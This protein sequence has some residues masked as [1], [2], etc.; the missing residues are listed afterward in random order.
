MRIERYFLMTDYSLW[1]VIINGDSPTPIV[2]IEGA[3]Q[4]T[5]ILSADQKLARR[6]ELKARGTLL[7][8]LPDK[9]Q[10]KFN[11][12]K[13]AK[14]LM[15][16]IE[17]R[18]QKLISQLE[19]HGR[20]KTNLEEHSLDDLFNSL[21]IFETEVRH[22]SSL[23]NSTQNLAFMSSSNIDSTTDSVSAATSVSAVCAQLH[24]SSHPNINSLSN[25][26]IFS[27]FASQST[28]P[29]LDNEDLKQIDVDDLKE[30]DL[31]WQMAMLTMRARRFLQKTRR[32]LGDNRVTTIGFDM[33]KVECY[34]CHR[35]GHF[36]Q[37]CKSPK[38]T[39]RTEEEPANFALMAISSSSSASD[40]EVKSCSKAY[41]ELHSQ[42][43]K[44]TVEYRK[45]QI[46]ILLYQAESDSKSLSPSSHSGRIQPSGRYNAVPPP[47]TW[48]FMPPKPDLVFHTA[49]ITVETTHSAFTIQLSPAKPAQDVSHTTRPMAPIIEDWVSDTEDEFEPNDPQNVP[50][51][52]QS[53]EHVKP[54]GHSAQPVEAS[55]LAAT[56]ILTSPKT[57]CSGK[58]KNRK[59]CFVCRSVDHLIKDLL[60]KSKPVF[61]TDV[62]Q[63]SDVVPR[64]MMSRPRHAHPLNT[65]SN[66]SIRRYKTRNQFSKTSNSSLKVTVAKVSMV[67]AVKGKKRKWGNPQYALKDKG[68][69]DSGCSQHMTGNMSYLS[70][71]LELNGGYVAFGGNPK[72][73]KILGKG[74]IK[75]G[76]STKDANQK[77]HRSLPS[78]WS[79]V[80]LIT[81]TKQGVDTLNFDDL[82]NNLRVFESD[83]EESA[84]QKGIK[85]V[86]G[87]M[88]NTGY[89]ARDNRKRSTK[90][91]EHKAMVTIDGEGVH[92]I[93]HA[94]DDTE[95]YA[96]MA[97]NSS[98]SGSDTK[99]TSC[100]KVCEESYAKLKKL[101][102]EQREQL[103]VA[104]IEIKAYTLALKK[105]EAQFVCHQK[106][107]LAYEEKIWFMKI[108]LDDKTNV[109]IYHKKLL[110]EAEKEKKELKTKLENFQSSSKGHSKLLNSQMSP[111]DNLG[112]GYGSQIHD[113]FLSYENEVFASVFDSRSSDVENSPMNDKFAKVEGMHAVPPPMIGNY[114]PPKFDF[115]IDESKFTYSPK[116]STTSKS[117]VKTSY[118][119]SYDFSSSEETL[120]T[121]PKPVANEPKAVSEPKVWPDAPIIE[122]YESD[123]DGEHIELN[124]QKGKHTDP[125]ENKPV[126]NN[127][128]IINHQNKFVPV[129]L[130]KTGRFPVNAARQNFTSQASS[131][132]TARKV[133]TA[134]PKMNEIRP[135]HNVYTS[136]SPIR[137][138]F[139]RTTAPKANFAQ[140]KFNTARDKSDFQIRIQVYSIGKKLR[141]STPGLVLMIKDTWDQEEDIKKEL[142]V[143]K[144]VVH[145]FGRRGRGRRSRGR[146]RRRRKGGAKGIG[147]IPAVVILVIVFGGEH[148]THDDPNNNYTSSITGSTS[149]STSDSTACIGNSTGDFI[150]CTASNSTSDYIACISNST[151]DSIAC[152]SNS[153][154]RS[155]LSQSI[156]S[157]LALASAKTD[158]W[159]MPTWCHM[160]NSTLTGNARLHNIKQRD[161][162]ST[163][164]FIRRYKLESRDVKGVPECIRISRFVHGITNPELIKRLHDKILKTVDDDES[165][166]ILPQGRSGSFKSQKE[167]HIPT[168]ETT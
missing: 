102:D 32:N 38:D 127:V 113:G 82:Y 122:E 10:L 69:I 149:N 3:V 9:H 39:K 132:S 128:Q 6:N 148:R 138:P 45:Y 166:N 55:I 151:I 25:A 93:S 60:T 51:F 48:N 86:K 63:V 158:R 163:E 33:S 115:R 89:K 78:S 53:T 47:I 155:G 15:E 143:N 133:N 92:W 161:G 142:V 153:T 157:T 79:Q 50:S 43:E 145:L 59:T 164:D 64:I 126:W 99:V 29:Q 159:A 77:F 68:V 118:L 35:K 152:T 110:A 87:E 2:V 57:N 119:D 85:T 61:V 112:L 130:T 49:P 168:M 147:G 18:L 28:S 26:V 156:Y 106:N 37:E 36:A 4:P 141:V 19:I 123:S 74:K 54:S 120:E 160:F 8:A 65:K 105:V 107:Q 134:R 116:Q 46:D 16:A 80:S 136:H 42:Y 62:R 125:R 56:P 5:T 154:S 23:S 7:M 81:R 94:E 70:D 117:N 98:N 11:S 75:I 30:M 100:S 21:K 103:G 34:N 31:R 111:K 27:F 67:S 150:A 109:R 24:V 101:Y 146:S 40:N 20:N 13:D 131:T 76:V 95:D 41:D 66:P 135:R 72:G 114:M 96:L 104:S 124:K 137:R 108:D 52:V 139:N 167:E 71:F 83:I 84:D 1:E 22:S 165:Y 14:I 91:D 121:V 17:K 144:G 44:L 58:R 12:H 88:Q 97:F 140:H 162:E 73:G 129:V 90:P